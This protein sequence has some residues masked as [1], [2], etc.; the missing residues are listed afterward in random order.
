MLFIIDQLK[1]ALATTHLPL[2]DVPQAITKKNLHSSLLILH[3]H[4]KKWFG[5]NTFRSYQKEIVEGILAQKD[6]LAILP[7]GAGKSLCYQL[8]SLLV[9]G[10]AIVISPLISFFSTFRSSN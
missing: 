8:P 6:V 5:Y 3:H 2:K 1:V 4:L 9:E 7:T 10:T